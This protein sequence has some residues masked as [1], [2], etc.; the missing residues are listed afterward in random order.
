MEAFA[1]G[2]VINA[3]ANR[4]FFEFVL[5]GDFVGAPHFE[6]QRL[7]VAHFFDFFVPTHNTSPVFA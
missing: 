1:V 4:E 3:L 5:A 7:S 6:C 2:N